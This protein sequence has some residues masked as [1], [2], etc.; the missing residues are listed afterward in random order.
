MDRIW[1]LVWI[2]SCFVYMRT[3][4]HSKLLDSSRSG[5]DTWIFLNILSHSYNCPYVLVFGMIQNVLD[6]RLTHFAKRKRHQNRILT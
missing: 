1:K 2:S 3:K 5:N 4:D 6:I